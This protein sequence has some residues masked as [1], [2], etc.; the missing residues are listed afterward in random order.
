MYV[1]LI[2]FDAIFDCWKHVLRPETC[3]CDV[4]T[5]STMQWNLD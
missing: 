2:Y 3:D 5:S 4:A 1:L